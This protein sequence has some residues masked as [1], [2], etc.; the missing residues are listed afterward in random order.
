MCARNILFVAFSSLALVLTDSGLTGM[1]AR[2][3]AASLLHIS[4]VLLC[5][6]EFGLVLFKNS[7]SS[8]LLHFETNCQVIALPWRLMQ[9]LLSLTACCHVKFLVVID[10]IKSNVSGGHFDTG[11]NLPVRGIL[12]SGPSAVNTD[13]V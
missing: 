3:R 8:L 6:S 9:K 7:C 5:F 12:V 4:K 1:A 13:I 11:T 10:I 2:L